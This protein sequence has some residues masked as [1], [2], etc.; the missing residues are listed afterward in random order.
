MRLVNL[1]LNTTLCVLLAAG[2]VELFGQSTYG[3]ILGSVKDP[4]GATISTATVMVTDT[5]EN[6]IHSVHTN[7]NGD[8]QVPN[9]LP[10]HYR[11][12]VTDPG[13]ESFQATNLI[14][15]ARQTLRVDVTLQISETQETVSVNSAEIG[16]ITTDSQAIRETFTPDQLS[17][18]PANIRA[19]G[20]TSPYQ[21]LQVLPG[22]QADSSGNFAIQGNTPFMTQYSVDVIS[23]EDVTGNSPLQQAFPSSESFAEI[24]VQGVGGS[25]EYGQPGDVTT[26]SKSGTNDFYGGLFWY[27]QNTALSSLA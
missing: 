20:N 6:S 13:F 26:I 21:L 4:S 3:T 2:S 9:L 10:G 23:T 25:A 12:E 11:V 19:N 27:Q 15:T 14:L 8:Y 1:K 5:D 22:V 7:G 18:L 17:N 16:V 24:K